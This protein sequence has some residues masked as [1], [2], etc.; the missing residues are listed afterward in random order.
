MDFNQIEANFKKKKKNATKKWTSWKTLKVGRTA[1]IGV[2]LDLA[3][4]DD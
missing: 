1:E 3:K 4:R 2:C